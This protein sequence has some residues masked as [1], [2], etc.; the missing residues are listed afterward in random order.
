MSILGAIARA[1]ARITFCSGVLKSM[2]DSEAA[3][4]VA[5]AS[6]AGDG[7]ATTGCGAMADSMQ[8]DHEVLS[9]TEER[10]ASPLQRPYVP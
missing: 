7:L 9:V 5:A 2:V 6:P 4:K 10:P 1:R 8:L 3:A